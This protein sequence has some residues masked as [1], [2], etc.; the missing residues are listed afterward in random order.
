NCQTVCEN[1]DFVTDGLRAL[2]FVVADSKAN[3]VF[4]RHP[5]RSGEEIYRALREKGILVRHFSAPRIADYNRITVG[6]R[7]QM[8][9]LLTAAREILED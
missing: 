1:R 9:A 5:E 8:Q 3:F 4:A 6:T 7:A 2:G